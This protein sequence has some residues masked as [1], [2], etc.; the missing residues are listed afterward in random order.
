MNTEQDIKSGTETQ[1][2]A[3]FHFNLSIDVASKQV[4]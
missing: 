2:S 1:S 3:H 4:F